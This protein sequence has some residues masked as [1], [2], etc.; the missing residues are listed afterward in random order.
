MQ[1]A[2]KLEETGR[3]CVDRKVTTHVHDGGHRCGRRRGR[4]AGQADEGD[5]LWPGL[6]GK[7]GRKI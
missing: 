6:A 5:G 1:V 2:T 3:V 4:D 7:L